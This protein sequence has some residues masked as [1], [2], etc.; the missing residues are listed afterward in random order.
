MAIATTHPKSHPP[1]RREGPLDFVSLGVLFVCVVAIV[2]VLVGVATVGTSP[3]A[4]ILPTIVGFW[5]VVTLR[6]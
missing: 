6:R 4:I 5:S 2:L 3:W 1:K